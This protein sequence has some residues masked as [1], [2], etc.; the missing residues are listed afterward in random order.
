MCS[1]DKRAALCGSPPLWVASWGGDEACLRGTRPP[2]MANDC[3]A[4]GCARRRFGG[5][6]QPS[7]CMSMA[8]GAPSWRGTRHAIRV[9][10]PTFPC[11]LAASGYVSN[12]PSPPES[13]RADTPP[14]DT[15][16]SVGSFA[17]SK[18][19]RRAWDA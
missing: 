12:P 10:V 14:S 16:V 11:R 15:G 13:T 6:R 18:G 4:M 3:M 19:I 9:D 5:S 1:F 7:V 8:P 2:C 17:P